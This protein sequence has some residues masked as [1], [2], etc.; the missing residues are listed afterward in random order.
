MFFSNLNIGN[1]DPILAD[2]VASFRTINHDTE[3]QKD[4][5]MKVYH[6]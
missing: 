3:F 1:N 6:V 5:H 2:T 4:T